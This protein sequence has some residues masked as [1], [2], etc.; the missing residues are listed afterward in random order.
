MSDSAYG[1][2]T[3][4]QYHRSSSSKS[5]SSNLSK[6]ST[7]GSS[8]FACYKAAGSGDAGGKA[9]PGSTQLP[10]T[11]SSS[12]TTKKKE[13]KH[14][15]SKLKTVVISGTSGERGGV[16]G[17]S[18]SKADQER[19]QVSQNNREIQTSYAISSDDKASKVAALSQALHHIDQFR[20]TQELKEDKNG[21]P[22][23]SE[24]NDLANHLQ[25]ASHGASTKSNKSFPFG[26]AG[27]VDAT[28]IQITEVLDKEQLST[29][30]GEKNAFKKY[31][32]VPI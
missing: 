16:P 25:E 3:T 9:S 20:K 32:Y 11:G 18:Q 6:S 28:K 22:D 17:S 8:G 26:G 24:I 19:D 13:P 31:D 29:A 4:S 7:S 15:K 27:T 10:P 23:A 5:P 14:K 2:L 1:S 21:G 30:I 12:S